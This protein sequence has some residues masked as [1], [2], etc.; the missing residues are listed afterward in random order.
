MA[1][2]TEADIPDLT[3]RTM[4]VTG[5][6]SGLGLRAVTVLARHG[7]RVVLACR[8]AERGEVALRSI[9]EIRR[10]G[11]SGPTGPRRPRLGARGGAAHP[12]ADR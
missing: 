5:A 1:D 12:R 2:W 4:V 10:Q 3:G 11:R 9:T 7:A 8:S 6:N